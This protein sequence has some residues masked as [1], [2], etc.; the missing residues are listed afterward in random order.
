M[1]R[2]ARSRFGSAVQTR[3]IS[4]RALAV[5][6]GIALVAIPGSVRA[7]PNQS[8]AFDLSRGPGAERCPDREAL[9]AQV[10]LR[11]AQPRESPHA[12]VADHV[13]IA[14][15]RSGNNYVATISTLG[16]DSGTRRLVDTSQDCAGLAEALSLMLAMIADGRPLSAEKPPELVAPIR[17]RRAWEVGAGVLGAGNILGA[18]TLGYSVD[19]LWHPSPHLATGLT[20][21]WMPD[22]SIE[23]GPGA[24]K[25]SVEAGLARVCWGILSF[26]GRFF[27]ALC[28]EFG[29]GVLQGAGEGY[30]DA[31]STLRPWL[32][33]GGTARVGIRIY[34]SLAMMVY[35]GGLF[36]LRNEQLTI[37]GIGQVY[38]SGHASWVAGTVLQVRIW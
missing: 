24:T 33:A 3:S 20:G 37:G 23:R 13:E 31:K 18:P 2:S 36:P 1:K 8:V 28:G 35:G 15:V 30:L 22:R 7:A 34:K 16:L 32:M 26:G 27:P 38:E 6:V 19:V 11:L 29:A 12:P 14:V 10:E 4:V 9:A 21:I 5:G 25:V 17:P